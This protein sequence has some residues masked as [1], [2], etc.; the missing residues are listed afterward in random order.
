MF[1]LFKLWSRKTLK[2]WKAFSKIY[3]RLSVRITKVLRKRIVGLSP[4]GSET[5]FPVQLSNWECIQNPHMFSRVNTDTHIYFI[6]VPSS[7]PFFYFL[8]PHLFL[9]P[10]SI[11][12]LPLHILSDPKP[13]YYNYQLK[14]RSLTLGTVTLENGIQEN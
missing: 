4:K 6:P 12:L 7:L 5:N 9:Y 11:L 10:Y 1:H 14:Q 8:S 2:I 13:S 3:N